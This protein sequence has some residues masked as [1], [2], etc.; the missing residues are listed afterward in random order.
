MLLFLLDHKDG[1]GIYNIGSGKA[2]TWNSLAAAIFAAMD[3]PTAIDYVDMPPHLRDR[4][5]YYTC[6]EM[7]RLQRLGYNRPTMSLTEAVGDYIRNYT[8]QGK[9]LGDED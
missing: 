6:A 4:Y 7:A 5:Q 2:E 3:L 8:S 9:F 1:M